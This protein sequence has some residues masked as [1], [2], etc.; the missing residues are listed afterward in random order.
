[1]HKSSASVFKL[2]HPAT[3]IYFMQLCSSSF[4]IIT[5]CTCVLSNYWH[6][7]YK[8]AM[9]IILLMQLCSETTVINFN[10]ITMC[11]LSNY[12]QQ[13]CMKIISLMHHCRVQ[14]VGFST[15]GHHCSCWVW[16]RCGKLSITRHNSDNISTMLIWMPGIL[17]AP[18]TIAAGYSVDLLGGR[19]EGITLAV[20]YNVLVC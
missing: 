18:C 12:W 19:P 15:T 11:V 1:M 16:C 5:V 4:N 10:I 2:D 6:Q 17:R 13:K 9:K 14:C 8:T 3:V 7:K 20:G